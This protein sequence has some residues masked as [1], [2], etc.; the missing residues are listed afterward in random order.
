[1][2]DGPLRTLR[3][4]WFQL[5][6]WL[7]IGLVVL[8]IPLGLSGS[9]LV[10]SQPL[11]RALAPQ[12][13]ATSGAPADLPASAYLAAAR[14]AFGERDNPVEIRPLEVRLP[15]QP[16]DPVTVTGRSGSAA[17]QG[18]PAASLTAW[19]DPRDARVLDVGDPRGG[20]MGLIHRLHGALAIPPAP[21][22]GPGVGRLIVGWLGVAMAVSCLTGLWLWFP[23]GA[24]ERGWWSRAFRWRRSPLFTDNL[25]HLVGFWLCLPLL[26]LSLTGVYIAFPQQSHALFGAPPPAVRM[27]DADRAGGGGGRP[28]GERRSRDRGDAP[29]PFS[30]DQA[31][32]AALSARPGARAQVITLPSR[33]TPAWKI[34]FAGAEAPVLVDAASGAVTPAPP[35]PARGG[36]P[37]SRWMRQ[38]HE[39]EGLGPV[40]TWLSF[41]AGLAPTILGVT[42]VWLWLLKRRR[43][44]LQIRTAGPT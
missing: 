35:E 12:R 22:S 37:I 31:V 7:G 26:L 8:M 14:Q 39:G 43:R 10:F 19:L 2:A 27:G 5:H 40:W 28:P 34:A 3:K 36:D 25:H 4:I 42:G 24:M 15:M 1:M 41:A 20:P 23:R 32:A 11:G 30:I 29:T 21:G 6:L 18:R 9:A 33:R 38:T 44:R 13:Y 17:G 16:Q